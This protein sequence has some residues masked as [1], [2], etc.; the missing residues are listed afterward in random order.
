MA[1]DATIVDWNG[2]QGASGAGNS[3][4]QDDNAPPAGF[5][6]VDDIDDEVP[7]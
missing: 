3:Y 1:D 7:F 6:S 2:A 4:P 5:T